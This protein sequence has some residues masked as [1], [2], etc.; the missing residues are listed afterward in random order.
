MSRY[1]LNPDRLFDRRWRAGHPFRPRCGRF[2]RVATATLLVLLCALIAAYSYAT[3]ARRV[4]S[5][6]E[7]YLS[8]LTGGRVTIESAS[9]SLFEGFKLT[10]VRVYVDA[11]WIPSSG[12]AATD[13]LLFSARTIVMQYDPASLLQ[14]KV[15]ADRII[16][17]KPQV[18]LC[19]DVDSN[20]WNYNRLGRTTRPKPPPTTT[21]PSAPPPLPEILLRNARFEIAEKR[22]GKAATLGFMAI[23]GQFTPQLS[24]QGETEN[25]YSFVMQSRGASDALGPL[26]SG[27]FQT[28]T[29][30]VIAQLKQFEFGLDARAMLPTDVAD[31]WRR[32]ELGGRIDIPVFEYTP[33]GKG[34]SPR[35]RIEAVLNGVTLKVPPEEWMS[36]SEISRRDDARAALS[37]LKSAYAAAGFARRGGAATDA[38]VPPVVIPDD[39]SADTPSPAAASVADRHHGPADVMASQLDSAPMELRQVSGRFIFTEAGIEIR[40]LAG[41]IENNLLQISGHVDSYSP[42]AKAS[43]RVASSP[44][45]D[46]HIPASPRYIWSLPHA[47]REFYTKTRFQGTCGLLFNI[48]RRTV[49]GPIEAGGHV[50]LVDASF[51][52]DEFPYPVRQTRGRIALTRDGDSGLDWILMQ[53]V[54]GR[55]AAGGPNA[56]RFLNING[57]V[58]PIGPGQ[59]DPGGLIRIAIDDIASEAALDKAFPGDVREA[60]NLFDAPGKGIFPIFRGN[61]VVEVYKDIGAPGLFKVR[62]DLDIAKADGML[63]GF[64]YPLKDVS[65]RVQ[66]REGYAD[67]INVRIPHPTADVRVEGIA[68]WKMPSHSVPPHLRDRRTNLKVTVRGLP[69]DDNLLSALPKDSAEWIAKTGITG[70]IDVDGVLQGGVGGEPY[71]PGGPDLHYDLAIRLREGRIQPKGSDF[72]VAGVSGAMHLTPD[73]L[74]LLSLEGTRDQATLRAIGQVIFGKDPRSML[75]VSGKNLALDKPLYSLLPPD[76]QEAWDEIRPNGTIDGEITYAGLST[77][78]DMKAATQPA[79]TKPAVTVVDLNTAAPRAPTRP[80][81][82]LLSLPAGDGRDEVR[83]EIPFGLHG[84][85]RPRELS[86]SIRTVPYLLEKLTGEVGISPDRVDFRKIAATH[87]ETKLTIDGHGVLE[88]SAVWTLAITAKDL[89][90]DAE[91]RQALPDTLASLLDSVK[92]SGTLDVNLD[93]FVY[94]SAPST[95]VS[96]SVAAATTLATT[97]P[98][99]AAELDIGG[100]IRLSGVSMDAGVVLE[101]VTGDIRLDAAIRGGRLASLGGALDIDSLEM[102]GRKVAN[103]RAVVAKPAGS[104]E[105]SLSRVQATVGGGDLAGQITLLSPDEGPARYAISLVL[106]NA[107][108]RELAK[109]NGEGLS[110]LLTASLALEGAWGKQAVRRGRGDVVVNG[111]EMY[112]MPLMLGLMQVTNLSLPISSPFSSGTVRYSVDGDKVT[113]ERIELRSNN[114]VMSGDGTLDFGTKQ[115]R[116]TFV[117]DNPAAFKIPFLQDVWRG[118]QQELLRIHVKGTV[119]EPT[120]E[121]RV[122]STFTTSVDEVFKGEK[123]RK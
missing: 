9:L 75:V 3:D 33:G 85:L 7:M 88:P 89:P 20:E 4:R 109:E 77:P 78:D 64:P 97:Q 69:I 66:V 18:H 2:R 34:K 53:G 105:L 41:R 31:W 62:V 6:A 81:A 14:G 106:R 10:G 15:Q 28:S 112:R 30:R 47:V 95:N 8:D 52:F 19:H 17:E 92:A 65:G 21:A 45:E 40:D 39:I 46:L 73:K 104:D 56:D 122:L 36:A 35:F 82:L 43:I 121:N 48:H 1:S 93:K 110:G 98:A 101:K 96:A 70:L 5:L 120:V 108:L 87:G 76:A 91:L 86:A 123:P 54:R 60:L 94:R 57:W 16:V 117:T 107:D 114:V 29:G 100:T 103:L 27:T 102:A 84:V 22:H 32:H 26:V 90:A 119:Q 59:P 115:V 80:T 12:P 61:A 23:D 55:G 111:K 58:G 79:E 68:A 38:P 49:G 24:Q 13:A 83:R 67:I 25:R 11:D 99:S 51:V 50:D 44:G 113:F 63:V 71:A 72:V 74:D 116:M 37:S 118:A 42:D